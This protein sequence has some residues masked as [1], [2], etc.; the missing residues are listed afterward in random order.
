MKR[1]YEY[2]VL[3]IAR[4][5]T[6]FNLMKSILMVSIVNVR[7]LARANF[8]IRSRV[9]ELTSKYEETTHSSF[10]KNVTMCSIFVYSGAGMWSGTSLGNNTQMKKLQ[11]F[12][13]LL[14]SIRFG[15]VCRKRK[16][17]IGGN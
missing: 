16:S 11:C 12:I 7:I 15:L 3:R 9:H 8:A 2:E 10:G 6:V 14:Y 4:I 13:L 17:A 1:Q 5:V